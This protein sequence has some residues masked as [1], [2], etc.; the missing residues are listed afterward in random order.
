M[1]EEEF[2]LCKRKWFLWITMATKIKCDAEEIDLK[3]LN[4][5]IIHH[6]QSVLV[7]IYIGPVTQHDKVL[8]LWLVYVS[9]I[10]YYFGVA[11]AESARA[12]SVQSF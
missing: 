12:D 1:V 8:I 2:W 11:P 6:N 5:Q 7:T 10:Y 4:L 9:G 3:G